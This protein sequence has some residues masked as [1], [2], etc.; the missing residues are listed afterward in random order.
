MPN[1]LP[2]NLPISA[3]S[4]IPIALLPITPYT[5][6]T[7]G[8]PRK[9]VDKK[10]RQHTRKRHENNRR[11]HPAIIQKSHLYTGKIPKHHRQIHPRHPH[12]HCLAANAGTQRHH[13]GL[14]DPLQK[15]PRSPIQTEQHQQHAD[16]IK[17]LLRI[18]RLARLPR[19][20]LKNPAKSYLRAGKRD[21]AHRIRK[22]HQNRQ[23]AGHPRQ[24]A[25]VHHSGCRKD[26]KNQH[27]LQRKT[28]RD[29]FDT[30]TKKETARLLQKEKHQKRSGIHHKKRKPGGPQQHL[31]GNEKGRR[32]SRRCTGKSIPAKP[33]PLLRAH[34]LQH[35]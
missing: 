5:V 34:L 10:S 12:L 27:I 28:P 2:T 6:T 17:R 32:K 19:H 9:S 3:N 21:D 4:P 25:C 7:R 14:C 8:F 23:R 13:Q 33:P 1:H 18:H 26:R 16:R 29:L 30:E 11:N 35:A 22:T 20:D 24:R 15:I 31:D